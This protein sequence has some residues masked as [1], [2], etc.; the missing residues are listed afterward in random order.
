MDDST[1]SFI[2]S[3][4]AKDKSPLTDELEFKLGGCVLE[5]TEEEPMDL[6]NQ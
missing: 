3:L 2:K 4:S 5:L 1:I 6:L